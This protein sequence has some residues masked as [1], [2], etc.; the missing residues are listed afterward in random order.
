ME[1]VDQNRPRTDL[2]YHRSVRGKLTLLVVGILLLTITCLT[3]LNYGYM[4][5]VIREE[6]RYELELFGESLSAELLR[7]IDMEERL[8]HSSALTRTVASL[9]TDQNTSSEQ[10]QIRENIAEVVQD[11]IRYNSDYRRVIVVDNFGIVVGSTDPTEVGESVASDRFFLEGA[12]RPYIEFKSN[13]GVAQTL[14][15]S[16]PIIDSQGVTVGV[17]SADV[18]TSHLA[19]LVQSSKSIHDSI[20]VRCAAGS[21]NADIQYLFYSFDDTAQD[22][23]GLQ[24]DEAMSNALAGMTGFMDNAVDNRGIRVLTAYRPVGYAD[25]GLVTQVDQSEAFRPIRRVLFAVSCFGLIIAFISGVAATTVVQRSLSGIR[26][27]ARA[28]RRMTEGDYSS[29]IT[30]ESEDEIGELGKDFNA[31]SDTVER[32]TLHLEDSVK[33]RTAQLEKSKN[34][35]RSL[36][37]A[38]ERNAELMDSDLER[39]EVIQRSLLPRNPPRVGGFS[40]SGLYIP[41]KNVGGDVYDV[42]RIDERHI[43]LVLA[44][45]TGHGVSAAMLTVLFKNRLDIIEQDD[46]AYRSA[47][48]SPSASEALGLPVQSHSAIPVFTRVNEELIS[49]VV[50]SSMFVTALFCILDTHSGKFSVASAGHPPLLVLRAYGEVETIEASGPALGLYSDAHFSEESLVL[51]SGDR[52]LMYTDG[53]FNLGGDDRF[54]LDD[55]AT[56]LGEIPHHSGALREL[57]GRI[58]DGLEYVDRDDVTMLLIDV[59]DGENNFEHLSTDIFQDK[60]ESEIKGSHS[61]R[62]EFADTPDNLFLTYHGRVTWIHGQSLPNAVKTAASNGKRV[63]VDLTQCEYLDSAMLGTLHETA[64]ICT[65]FNAKLHIQNADSDIHHTFVELGMRD[66][67]DCISGVA[68]PV[69]SERE[70]L[71]AAG[72]DATTQQKWLLRAHEA[73]ASL[74]ESNRDEFKDVIEELKEDIAGIQ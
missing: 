36:V 69:P 5:A 50:G 37:V 67:L 48:P 68:V 18:D 46:D 15:M 73:L 12:T 54:T 38:L 57:L 8:L 61:P 43:G 19:E 39:A 45:S 53:L 11:A 16:L 74:N 29:R 14:S 17:A 70:R 34:Q 52:V 60:I 44:D 30:V 32:H 62:I 40:F 71:A 26:R 23:I 56:H 59:T 22:P 24:V 27:L 41:G 1:S 6:V 35:L 28:A 51:E 10:N 49:D 13:G 33:R 58:T 9:L 65:T 25:W 42:I 64:E 2:P 21:T 3:V 20:Q 66:V 72:M 47:Q 7:Y 63:V 31:M 4:R 55:V